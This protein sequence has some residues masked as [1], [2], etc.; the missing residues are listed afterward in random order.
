MSKRAT[1]EA[2]EREHYVL[3]LRR[4]AAEAGDLAQVAVCDR[5]LKGDALAIA[6]CVRIIQN[7][8]AQ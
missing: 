3:P 2:F 1:L 4:E 7:A 5:A 6:A 8:S